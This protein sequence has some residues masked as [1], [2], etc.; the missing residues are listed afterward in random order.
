M[1]KDNRGPN[2]SG[3]VPCALHDYLRKNDSASSF[4]K[5]SDRECRLAFQNWVAYGRTPMPST[6][7]QE[8]MTCPLLW[9]RHRFDT[10]ASCLQHVSA[11]PWLPN[12]FYWCPQCQRAE[13]FIAGDAMIATVDRSVSPQ[14]QNSKM[15]RAVSF[16]KHLGR[17]SCAHPPLIE[18]QERRTRLD[19]GS[20]NLTGNHVPMPKHPRVNE[21]TCS[22]ENDFEPS[23]CRQKLE[24]TLHSPSVEQPSRRTQE[25]DGYFIDQSVQN[26]QR[27]LTRRVSREKNLVP[28]QR[29]RRQ[30][31]YDMEGNALSPLMSPNI[32]SSKQDIA[33][34]ATDDPL[35]NS[36]QLGDTSVTPLATGFLSR[37]ER[38]MSLD[39]RLPTHYGPFSL[40]LSAAKAEDTWRAYWPAIAQESRL[41]NVTGEVI[42]AQI[43]NEDAQMQDIN[44]AVVGFPI[45]QA[46][47]STETVP[48]KY[49][50][51]AK[52]SKHVAKDSSAEN[53]VQELHRLV[54]GLN[55]YWSEEVLESSDS[56]GIQ[57]TIHGMSA[58][59]AGLRSLQQCFRGSFTTTVEGVLSLAQLALSCAYELYEQDLAFPW[60]DLL[61]DIM[62]WSHAIP[63]GDD[64]QLYVNTVKV[65]W[66]QMQGPSIQALPE[67]SPDPDATNQHTDNP[68]SESKME[69]TSFHVTEPIDIS[70]AYSDLAFC[71]VPEAS[72]TEAT[73]F[74]PRKRG[75]VIRTCSRYLNG[76]LHPLIVAKLS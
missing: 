60:Q 68:S 48:P 33:E 53:L 23:Q 73:M 62:D 37:D 51:D 76:R 22:R 63:A 7:T 47:H 15:R 40:S 36:S 2:T 27:D 50:T 57:A 17:K 3:T 42:T 49:S 56:T 30:T 11:C 44:A 12:A 54:R 21:D 72:G 41:Q 65:L 6:A 13:R 35:F 28:T 46:D 64:R 45:S 59:E 14:R 43:D 31:L 29:A 1:P 8:P 58:F 10:F 38:Q 18:N 5:L 69:D 9:C 24:S 39:Q 67:P 55:Y 70:M 34:L 25:Y 32:E 26:V 74:E 61:G 19:A 4:A 20:L 71:P 16:F 75:L 66:A 52:I